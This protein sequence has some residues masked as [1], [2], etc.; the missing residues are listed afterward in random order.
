MVNN[1]MIIE[2]IKEYRK[3]LVKIIFQNNDSLIITEEDYFTQALYE[4]KDLTDEDVEY[5]KF[6]CSKKLAKSVAIKFVALKYR[7]VFEVQ[8]KLKDKEFSID[9]IDDVIDDLIKYGYLDDEEYVKRYISNCNNLKPK[10]KK[11]IEF[12]LIRKGIE[13][14]LILEKLEENIID[15]FEIA[16][17]L[18]YKR[19]GNKNY[20]KDTLKKKTFYFLSNRGFEYSII[21]RVYEKIHNKE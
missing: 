15:E 2:V 10:S 1:M 18:A 12:E 13:K 19:F 14:D 11:K 21:K 5:L 17:K 20:D 3:G 8:D 9:V 7:T 16:Y 6:N 4:E